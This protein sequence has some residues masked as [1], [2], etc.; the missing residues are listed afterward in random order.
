MN[1]V[2]LI[3][4]AGYIGSALTKYLLAKNYKVKI[5]DALIYS[6]GY[7]MKEFEKNKNF[8]FIFGDIRNSKLTESL[9]KDVSDVVILVG[10]V[11]DPVTKKYPEIAEEL[12]RKRLKNYMWL[13]QG[14]DQVDIGIN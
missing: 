8:E 13:N 3:G 4:G 2:L 1:K 5:L 9:F 6:H 12:N 14:K 10:L 7:S 11:G